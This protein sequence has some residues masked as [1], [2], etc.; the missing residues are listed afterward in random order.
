MNRSDLTTAKLLNKF[1]L[2]FCALTVSLSVNADDLTLSF[3]DSDW[4][5]KGIPEGQQCNR[6]KGVD[7][8][9]PELVVK[10]IPANTTAIILEFSDRSLA[11]MNNG[12]H[13]KVGYKIPV[14]ATEV[15]IPRVPGHTET[16]PENF[17]VVANHKAPRWDTAGAYLP[18]C[19]G[20]RGN[21]YF[22]DVK[23]VILSGADA[24]NI[25]A[26]ASIQM[27]TY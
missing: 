3:T 2:I 12:G 6:F 27:A 17:F 15:T 23:A 4:S 13:G 24:S 21:Q 20:G 5:S 8:Q 18:P 10:N 14:G 1:A 25:L 19:S 9:S 11:S 16:L 7:P 22:I 26:E